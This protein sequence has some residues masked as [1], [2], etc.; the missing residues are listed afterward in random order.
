MKLITILFIFCSTLGVY[1]Q[2]ELTMS[3][4]KKQTIGDREIA[5]G[6][7]ILFGGAYLATQDQFHTQ[8]GQIPCFV[9]G[10]GLVL[11]GIRMHRS[12]GSRRDRAITMYLRKKRR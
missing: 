6:V 11:E 10:G 1:S 9:L 7:I 2:T 5:V 3:S 8:G 12:I 4:S